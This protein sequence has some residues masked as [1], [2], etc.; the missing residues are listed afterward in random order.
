MTTKI[1]LIETIGNGLGV[2]H[3]IIE[4]DR[5]RYVKRVFKDR[6]YVPYFRHKGVDI[7]ISNLYNEKLY[8]NYNIIYNGK[9]D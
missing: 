9:L 8:E 3:I 1:D 2:S 7:Y 5:K 6:S 4:V